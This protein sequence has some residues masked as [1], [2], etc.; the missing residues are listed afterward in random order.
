MQYSQLT[1]DS[2]SSSASVQL[3][4]MEPLW[5]GHVVLSFRKPLTIST[6]GSRVEKG[7]VRVFRLPERRTTLPLD[8][9]QSCHEHN[10]VHAQTSRQENQSMAPDLL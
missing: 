9:S 8:A 6:A 1:V 4:T 10:S 3:L 5:L 2:F 7:R